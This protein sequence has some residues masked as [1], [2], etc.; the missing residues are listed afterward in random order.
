MVVNLKKMQIKIESIFTVNQLKNWNNVFQTDLGNQGI[1]FEIDEEGRSAL[2]FP[3]SEDQRID[4]VIFKNET[5]RV[6]AENKLV[7]MITISTDIQVKAQLN[8]ELLNKS[9]PLT[10]IGCQ[11][12]I[13]G[14]GFDASRNLDGISSTQISI[15]RI[16]KNE[17]LGI[18]YA[19]HQLV[20]TL[21]VSLMFIFLL[22]A[23]TRQNRVD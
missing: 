16:P 2:L 23:L 11:K 22:I 1:R 15:E 18:P 3:I 5:I 14:G 6:G 4:G 7:A 21:L 13:S 10:E 8:G 17:K 12:P 19:T 20:A 9:F